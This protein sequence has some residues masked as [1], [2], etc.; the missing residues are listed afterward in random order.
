[1]Y[2]LAFAGCFQLHI[3]IKPKPCNGIGPLCTAEQVKLS[4]L[5]LAISFFFFDIQ[6]CSGFSPCRYATM[7]LAC[8]WYMVSISC[9]C[10]FLDLLQIGCVV[11]N[12]RLMGFLLWN[13]SLFTFS[14]HLKFE[15][16]GGLNLLY[17]VLLISNLL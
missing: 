17:F 6:D 9:T 2:T 3:V 15:S 16:Q 1:M 4:F 10:E 12:W 11:E 13:T 14:I 7:F 5:F 8:A